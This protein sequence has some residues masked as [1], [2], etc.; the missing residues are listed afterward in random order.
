M[1]GLAAKAVAHLAGAVIATTVLV[2]GGRPYQPQPYTRWLS[3]FAVPGP[4]GYVD[5]GVGGCVS[6][7]DLGCMTWVRPMA[8]VRITRADRKDEFTFAHELGHV[9]DFYVLYPLGL[10]PRFAAL[11]G[12]PWQTPRSEEYFADS[13]ALCAMHRRLGHTVTT[14]YGFRVT[15]ELHQRI[16]TLIRDAYS[17]WLAAPPSNSSGQVLP[18]LPSR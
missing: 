18:F 9:F 15:P 1:F 10:R 8:I 11:E 2:H 5:F 4:P 7:L 12:F 17:S 14:D 16:C 6:S 3:T 13:Y